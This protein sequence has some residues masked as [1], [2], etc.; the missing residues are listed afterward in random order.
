MFIA[1]IILLWESPVAKVIKN[2][3][4]MQE[5]WETWVWSLDGKDPL[6]EEMTTHSLSILAWGIP[7]T[8]EPDRLRSMGSQRV[9]HDWAT[10]HTCT[11]THKLYYCMW[12]PL[13]RHTIPRAGYN[14]SCFANGETE[15]S[16]FKLHSQDREATVWQKMQL[17]FS[18]MENT[19]KGAQDIG[20][21]WKIL[22]IMKVIRTR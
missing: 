3:P 19:H 20:T 18:N 6:E 12:I 10:E 14:Y 5:I 15:V 22:Q 21:S 17:S 1:N 13:H 4:T 8:E 7:W 11:H 9:G 2:L 16:K